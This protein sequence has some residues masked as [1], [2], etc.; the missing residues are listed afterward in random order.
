M[1]HMLITHTGTEQSGVHN[2]LIE[3]TVT[4]PK[5]ISITTKEPIPYKVGEKFIG[6]FDG[7]CNEVT[8]DG[9]RFLIC[10]AKSIET[11]KGTFKEMRNVW[12]K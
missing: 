3:S 12:R 1:V 11:K 2:Y 7:A 5:Y 10:N 9:F 4:M 8:D 6:R